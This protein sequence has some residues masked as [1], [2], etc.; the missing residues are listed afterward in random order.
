[1][2]LSTGWLLEKTGFEATIIS[3]TD[4]VTVGHTYR[5]VI[6]CTAIDALLGS[7]PLLWNRA[8]SLGGNLVRLG[9]LFAAVAMI[10]LVRLWLG[11]ALLR[12]HIP[13]VVGHEVTAGFFY[14]VLLVWIVRERRWLKLAD[15]QL[16]SPATSPTEGSR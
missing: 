4:F 1:M 6:S 16:G 11:F 12:H 2:I 5:F 9:T 10:N 15:R 14:F 13:W 7:V 8:L 3:A